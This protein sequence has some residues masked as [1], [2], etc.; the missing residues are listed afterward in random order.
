[1]ASGLPL[2]ESFL[3]YHIRDCQGPGEI[4]WGYATRQHYVSSAS[5]TPLF[6]WR[7]ATAPTILFTNQK[8][9]L[10]GEK[11]VTLTEASCGDHGELKLLWRVSG[12]PALLSGPGS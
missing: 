9:G 1:M 3:A 12:F 6:E 5:A 4:C 10:R 2:E 11:R 7:T 8:E